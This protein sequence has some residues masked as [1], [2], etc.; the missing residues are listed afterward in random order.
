MMK[1]L[2]KTLA[3]LSIALTA[4]VANASLITWSSQTYTNAPSPLK[5]LFGTGQFDQSGTLLYAENTGGA[6]VTFDGIAFSAPGID[7][8]NTHDGF[9]ASTV[10]AGNDISRNGTWV[11]SAGATV[12]LGPG[13]V[14][15]ALNPGNTYRIQLAL[16][17]GRNGQNGR[18]VSVDGADQG[19]Y[20]SG[21]SNVTWG[22]SL[23]ITGTF[24]AD[25]TSQSFFIETFN[26]NASIAGS[27]LNALTLYE[28]A[29]IPEPSVTALLS[30]GVLT[31]L[32]R[33][34]RFRK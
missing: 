10:G 11:G 24:V 34:R 27:Q 18:T 26:A 28:T 12:T 33:R 32:T 25:A 14:G 23:L 22:D 30:L 3:C 20:G 9:H 2:L 17:D 4:S 5:N 29:A 19:I 15:T 7:F 1:H 13:G 21:V 8:G 6:A 16:V 31:L